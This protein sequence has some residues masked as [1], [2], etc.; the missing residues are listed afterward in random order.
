MAKKTPK[1]KASAKIAKPNE[2]SKA[3]KQVS[4]TDLPRKTLEECLEVV[5]PI[6]ETYADKN[7]SR[8]EIATA[9]GRSSQTP[10][11]KYL[12]WGAQAYGLILRDGENYQLTE[13]SRKI[14]APESEGE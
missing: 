2:T 11:F 13:T 9:L 6:H 8:D 5:R 4:N 10:A 3:Q 12:I 14:F 7:V 1:K